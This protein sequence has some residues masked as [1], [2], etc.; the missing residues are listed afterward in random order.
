[1]RIAIRF[2]IALTACFV[3][4]WV[5]Y[6][7]YKNEMPGFAPVNQTSP[8]ALDIGGDF[9]LT[10]Q[11]GS[12]KT[13]EDFKGKYM[14][15]YF[16][17][18]FCPDICP[19]GLYNISQALKILKNDRD[20]V[21]PIFITID[22]ERDTIEALKTYGQNFDPNFVMLTG[23]EKNIQ[24]AIKAYHVYAKKTKPQGTSAA[25]LM[26]HSTLVYLMDREGK[27]ITHFPHNTP[28]QEMAK[29]ILKHLVKDIKINKRSIQ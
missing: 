20:Q 10:D 26:D 7:H 6:N 18:A 1:M 25:Y 13:P 14:L 27:F 23:S 4:T 19:M 29:N 3:G 24:K 12:I 5:I 15:V 28:P 9:S 11:S 22:P 8:V 2:A 16:G 21:V 17:Y